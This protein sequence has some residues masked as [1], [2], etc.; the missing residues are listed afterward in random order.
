MYKRIF[1]FYRN[2]EIEEVKIFYKLNYQH[3]ILQIDKLINQGYN[4]IKKDKDIFFEKENGEI[5]VI[6]NYE[7]IK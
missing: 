7:E 2:N 1:Q 4:M 5:K 6:I 3:M